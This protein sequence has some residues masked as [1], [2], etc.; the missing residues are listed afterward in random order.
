M[1]LSDEWPF[2]AVP[3]PICM[4]HSCCQLVLVYSVAF[5]HDAWPWGAIPYP[6]CMSH[7]CCQLDGFLTWRMTLRGHSLPSLYVPFLL[8]VGV[9]IPHGFLTWHMALRGHSKPNLISHSCPVHHVSLWHDTLPLGAI[10]DPVC[11]SDSCPVHHVSLWHESVALRGRSRPR[12]YVMF[13]LSVGASLLHTCLAVAWCLP[14]RN[15]ST[16]RIS[17]SLWS[18]NR[19]HFVMWFSVNSNIAACKFFHGLVVI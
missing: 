15:Q 6:V 8:S 16:V 9:S 7:S 4:T 11:I 10:A 17:L 13:L 1:V 19:F 18:V 14:H 3:D 2:G 12:L 5:W